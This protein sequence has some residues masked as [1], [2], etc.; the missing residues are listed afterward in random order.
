MLK[1]KRKGFT[2]VELIVVLVILGILAALLIPALTGYL[3]KA[4]EE[5]LVTECRN[6]VL[7]GQTTATQMYA[8]H[9]LSIDNLN[10]S[11]DKIEKLAEIPGSI[12]EIDCNLDTGK[13]TLLVYKA[14][15]N[16]YVLYENGDYSVVD[17]LKYGNNIQGYLKTSNS[18]LAKALKIAGDK[19]QKTKVWTALRKLYDEKYSDSKPVLSTQEKEILNGVSSETIESLTWKPTILGDPDNPDNIMMIA[20]NNN[21]SNLAYM[22]YYN[23]SYYYHSNGWNKKD[24][25]FVIDQ[26]GFDIEQLESPV[27]SGSGWYK[28]E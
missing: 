28:V 24:S 11:F 25:A 15:N 2:L 23:G 9:T 19:D 1:R 21:N 26:G 3:D 16:Q 17:E 27:T 8:N 18:L 12:E 4:N 13:I 7:A 14:T 20:S 5:K 10:S 22:I 6:A